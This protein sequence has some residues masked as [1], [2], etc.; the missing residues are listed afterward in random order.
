M[1]TVLSSNF[2]RIETLYLRG[3]RLKKSNT[4]QVSECKQLTSLKFLVLKG[5]RRSLS[6]NILPPVSS[7]EK[8]IF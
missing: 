4:I 1:E 2:V 5:C 3:R 7:L 6:G 8:R